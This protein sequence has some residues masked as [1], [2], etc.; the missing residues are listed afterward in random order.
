M[1]ALKENFIFGRVICASVLQM[2]FCEFKNIP[3]DIL[4]TI[5][6]SAT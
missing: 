5:S 1:T 4:D 6:A 3:L 2:E